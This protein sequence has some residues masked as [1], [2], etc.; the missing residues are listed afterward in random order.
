MVQGI[1]PLFKPEGV[2]SHDVVNRVRR[3]LGVRRVGHTGTLDPIATGVLVVCVGEA[4]RLAEYLSVHGKVYRT[5]IRL[6]LTTDTQDRTGQVLSTVDAS[7]IGEAD[8]LRAL[9]RFKGRIEQVPPMTSARRYQGKRLYALARAGREVDRPARAVTIARLDLLAFEPGPQPAVDLEVEC[10]AGTYIRT[11]A[12]DLGAALG[13]GGTMEDL[14]RTQAGLVR[15]E[16]CVT[17]EQ[18]E[19]LQACGRLPDVL[20]PPAWAMRDWPRTTVNPREAEALRC[21]RTLP[22][23]TGDLP[24]GLVLAL[25]E[26]GNVVAIVRWNGQKIRP[27]KVF[28][29]SAAPD[30]CRSK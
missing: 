2:T 11:L 23:P 1:L 4:T 13:V 16:D 30:C 9:E 24:V 20:R 3:I 29:V 8:V 12:A 10:S 26:G 14:V 28:G 27:Q 17:L 22:I 15:L 19:Q 5:R 18:L 7:G 6:G 25:D 21:G